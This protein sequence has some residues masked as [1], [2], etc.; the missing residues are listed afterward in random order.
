[1]ESQKK[2]MDEFYNISIKEKKWWWH[3]VPFAGR[4]RFNA[5][6]GNC[7]YL[8]PSR[9]ADWMNDKPFGSTRAIVSHE[10][11]HVL[12]RREEGPI[13]YFRYIFSR[14]HRLR[15]EIKAYAVQYIVRQ[16]YELDVSRWMFR[17]INLLASW[18]YLWLGE[19]WPAYNRT[20]HIHIMLLNAI[21]AIK[22]S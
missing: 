15:Y 18:R 4:N 9:Y 22:E 12:Q 8:T 20:A 13:M 3:L 14:K 6:S 1:M 5:F 19:G 11:I 7:I 17:K 21:D 10:T 2:R 16:Q